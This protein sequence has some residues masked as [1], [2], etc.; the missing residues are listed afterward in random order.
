MGHHTSVKK[1]LDRF[2]NYMI[3]PDRNRKE[4]SIS[5][6]VG[7]VRRIFVAVGVKDDL[8]IV[9]RNG[10]VDFRD[11]YIVK[12]CG[13]KGTK[14]SS[15]KKYLYSLIDF[16]EFLLAEDIV[17]ANVKRRDMHT[18]IEKNKQWRKNY[19]R[20]EKILKQKVC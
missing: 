9:F 20:Q 7:D 8:D 13:A 2:F 10:G 1:L 5:V 17:M 11:L 14:P 12:H 18:L 6:I 19:K 3:G 16:C 15:I 4:R